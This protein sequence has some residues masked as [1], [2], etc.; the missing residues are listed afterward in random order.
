MDISKFISEEVTRQGHD[1]TVWEDGGTRCL[2][3]LTGWKFAQD[4]SK[5]GKPTL[6]DILRI[7]YHME[8]EYN[9]VQGFRR[10]NVTVGWHN[11]PRWENVPG[12]MARLWTNIEDVVPEQ[13]RG[14]EKGIL[15]ADD[16]YLGFEAIH[17]FRDG[18]GRSGKILH[19]WLLG[20][21][22]DP[23]LVE[24]YFGMGNP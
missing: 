7:G 1:I 15:T 9:S 19:N 21:L 13:G 24:D 22:D 12:E 10:V 17:P 2:W 20:T 4:K 11:P 5:E 16:F 23:V 3:M 6:Q 14:I 8:P 18:N